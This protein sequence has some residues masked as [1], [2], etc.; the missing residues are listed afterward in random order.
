MCIWLHKI[1]I[2]S[3]SEPAWWCIPVMPAHGRETQ[4]EKKFKAILGFMV[5]LRPVWAAQDLVSE[6]QCLSLP[7]KTSSSNWKSFFPLIGTTVYC[8]GHSSFRNSEILMT[9]KSAPSGP[10]FGI[11][12]NQTWDKMKTWGPLTL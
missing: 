11:F 4:K 1:K 12:E 10:A 6:D 5:S 2:Q 7:F 9:I 3:S 8:D